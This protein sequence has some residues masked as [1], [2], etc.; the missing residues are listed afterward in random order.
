MRPCIR[1]CIP[2]VAV[3]LSASVLEALATGASSPAA[4]TTMVA[5]RGLEPRA[6]ADVVAILDSARAAGLPADALSAKVVEGTTKGASPERIVRVVYETFA[7]MRSARAVLG[8]DRSSGEIAAGGGALRAGLSVGDLQRIRGAS[9]DRPMTESL[10]VATDMVRRGVPVAD[11]VGAVVRLAEAGARGEAFLEL[12]ADVAQD[13]AAGVP[14]R[15]AALERARALSTRPSSK[16][17]RPPGQALPS[18]PGS[19]Q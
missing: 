14:P 6:R 1:R 4:V 12:Q 19:P 3:S 17:S 13:V 11:A 16:T 15:S 2:F 18:D 7:T 10:V 5:V 8:S 9:R